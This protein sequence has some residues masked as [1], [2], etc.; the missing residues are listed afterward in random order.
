LAL[1]A[2]W[3]NSGSSP[4]DATPNWYEDPPGVVHLEGVAGTAHRWRELN[5]VGVFPQAIWPT[6]TIFTIAATSSGTYSDLWINPQ[7][8]IWLI[9]ARSPAVA[10]LT[11]VSLD[12]ISF[13]PN[14]SP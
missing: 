12:N 8:Q 10:N 11:T 9:G 2:S 4:D 13:R 6:R 14:A 3:S 1:N 7:G 5:L